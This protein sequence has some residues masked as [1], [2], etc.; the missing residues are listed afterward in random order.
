MVFIYNFCLAIV[1]FLIPPLGV[2]NSKLQ[3]GIIGRKHT[4]EILQQWIKSTDQVIWFHCASLGEYEQGL[5]VFLKLKQRYPKHKIVLSFF[6]PSGYEIKKL[7]P[8]TPIVVYLP[9]DTKSNVKTFLDLVHPNLTVFVKYDLWPNFLTE[10]KQRASVCVLIS[11]LFRENQWF[12]KSYG[13]WLRQSLWAFD[14]IF[15]QNKYSKQLLQHIGYKAV[16]IAGDTRFDRVNHQLMMDNR[17]EFIEKFKSDQLCVVAGSIW[18]EDDA[19]LVRYI[20]QAPNDLKFILAPHNINK[21]ELLSIQKRLKKPTVLFSDKIN[22]KLSQSQVFIVDTIGILSKIYAYADIA[23]IGGAMGNTGLHNTLEPATFGVP[24]IIGKDYKKFPE[25]QQMNT[26]GGLFSVS[27]YF[28]LKSILNVLTTDVEM[29][30]KA[31]QQNKDYV[32]SS[33]GA[34]LHIMAKLETLIKE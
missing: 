24:I 23:Y 3:K 21:N 33:T 31:G 14:H 34:T 27:N 4:F 16:S 7:N 10:L 9:L 32:Q 28:E 1:S 25:A 30:Q 11:A 5:P 6:S 18:P 19:L 15:T 2:L 26:T 29:R 13:K 22:A 12:F 20:N 17:L 8:I